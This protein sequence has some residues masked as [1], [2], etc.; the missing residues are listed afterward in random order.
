KRRVISI[1][2]LRAGLDDSTFIG[3][4]AAE[5]DAVA[6]RWS[7]RLAMVRPG[8]DVARH[9]RAHGSHLSP[10]GVLVPDPSRGGLLPGD[11]VSHIRDSPS[12]DR[13]R[14]SFRSSIYYLETIRCAGFRPGHGFT[15][16]AGC[17]DSRDNESAGDGNHGST[18]VQSATA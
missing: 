10:R 8:S 7:G 9:R 18:L 13:D 4:R 15:R 3:R 16:C 14:L 11:G 12:A 1:V 2:R 6:P 17:I 5:V